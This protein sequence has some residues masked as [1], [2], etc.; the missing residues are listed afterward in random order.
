[1]IDEARF[2]T[3]A[4]AVDNATIIQAEEV[5]VIERAVGIG[6]VLCDFP[7]NA[8]TLILDDACAGFD[9]AAREDAGAV[10]GGGFN[11]IQRRRCDIGIYVGIRCN[12]GILWRIQLTGFSDES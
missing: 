6:P 3:A 7:Q 11:D 1:M 5:S 8:F 9:H 10:D 4:A 12:Y 2:I